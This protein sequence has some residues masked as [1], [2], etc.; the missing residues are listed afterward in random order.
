MI[1]KGNN[2]TIIPQN[3]QEFKLNCGNLTWDEKGKY[4][5]ILKVS[6]IFLIIYLLFF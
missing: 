3:K 5:K 4:F 6:E 1:D 2:Q